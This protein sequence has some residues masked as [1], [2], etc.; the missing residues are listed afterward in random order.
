MEPTVASSPAAANT[1]PVVA[2]TPGGDE[3]LRVFLH[4]RDVSCPVCSY[5]LRAQAENRCPECGARISLT[6]GAPE[7]RTHLLL[8]AIGPAMLVLGIAV[9]FTIVGIVYGTPP[10]GRHSAY[11]VT[12]VSG[13][14]DL[15]LVVTLFTRRQ[16]FLTAPVPAQRFV[17]AISWLLNTLGFAA[18]VRTF[19]G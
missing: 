10:P 9:L 18:A 16:K 15:F 14:I 2:P 8:L 6:V 17:V 19:I 4:D 13:V 1:E 7:V 3:L 5:N 12:L 11:A